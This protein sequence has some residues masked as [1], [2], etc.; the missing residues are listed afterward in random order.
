MNMAAVLVGDSFL[1]EDPLCTDVKIEIKNEILETECVFLPV[2]M[3]EDDLASEHITD[4]STDYS[5]EN[6]DPLSTKIKIEIKQEMEETECLFESFVK[7]EEEEGDLIYRQ[8]IVVEAVDNSVEENMQSKNYSNEKINSPTNNRL[9]LHNN[10]DIE[11][12]SEHKYCE[13][14]FRC[15]NALTYNVNAAG[16]KKE[17]KCRYCQRLFSRSNDLKKHVTIHT[18]EKNFTCNICQKSFNRS[19]CLKSHLSIHTGEKKFTCSFCQKSFRCRYNL[20]THLS[21]HTGE[22]RFTCNV[23]QKSFNENSRFKKHLSIHEKKLCNFCQKSFSDLKSHLII[24]ADCYHTHR[25]AFSIS[26]GLEIVLM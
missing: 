15:K 3:T 10:S 21:I 8:D 14:T 24:H 12:S 5:F 18:G 22:K 1:E 26:L 13:K 16:T 19:D 7:T 2:A 20:K 17:Y 9:K 4:S 25:L 23:C 6:K 11:C